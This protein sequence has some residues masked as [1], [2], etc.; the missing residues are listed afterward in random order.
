MLA[1]GVRGPAVVPAAAA[2][3]ETAVGVA[4]LNL[5]EDY[6]EKGDPSD[7]LT[8]DLSWVAKKMGLKYPQFHL[9]QR[10]NLGL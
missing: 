8:F 4:P 2:A 9:Q 3:A 10:N 7:K 1:S 5:S 6:S